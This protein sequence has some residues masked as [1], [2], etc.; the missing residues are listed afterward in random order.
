MCNHSI[1]T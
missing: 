1:S